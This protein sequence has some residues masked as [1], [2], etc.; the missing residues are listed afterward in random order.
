MTCAGQANIF[1]NYVVPTCIVRT[2]FCSAVNSSCSF[3]RAH[4]YGVWGCSGR[5]LPMMINKLPLISKPA[6]A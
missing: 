3:V 6:K 1:S 5:Q 2:S 4:I